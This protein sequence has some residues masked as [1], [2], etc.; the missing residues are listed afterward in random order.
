M[1]DVLLYKPTLEE[2][3]FRERLLK[4]EKTMAYNHAYGGV[5]SF[6]SDMW[7]DWY[8][9]WVASPQSE[10]FY[11]YVLWRGEFVGEVGYHYSDGIYIVNLIIYAPY[12][13]KGIGSEALKLLCAEAKQQG[14]SSLYDDIAIDNPGISI[15]LKNGFSVY[16]KTSEVVYVKKEL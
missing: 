6:T 9:Y 2:L 14:I 4:D 7:R 12:R 5:I 15:F 13:N 11:R 16:K 3:Y 1:S 8:D 10:R